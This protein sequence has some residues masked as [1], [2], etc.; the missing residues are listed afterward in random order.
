MF[1][2]AIELD[3]YGTVATMNS[4]SCSRTTTTQ[5]KGSPPF[6]KDLDDKKSKASSMT[7]PTAY[8]QFAFVG[9]CS[10]PTFFGSW[11]FFSSW[12]IIIITFFVGSMEWT[13]H[14]NAVSF[15]DT[16]SSST[17]T[18]KSRQ[19][20]TCHLRAAYMDIIIHFDI[21]ISI[22]VGKGRCW[23]LEFNFLF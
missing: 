12:K 19:D 1:G 6:L 10:R 14:A 3:I 2:L 22:S 7:S 20:C 15:L 23:L 9:P 16:I 17:G 21:E 18:W 11:G 5:Q 13:R 4:S 8:V